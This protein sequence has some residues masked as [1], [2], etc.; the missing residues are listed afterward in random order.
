MHFYNLKELPDYLSDIND[1]TIYME[2]AIKKLQIT[3]D[4]RKELL[5]YVTGIRKGLSGADSIISIIAAI[6][7]T[8]V[9]Y[10][11]PLAALRAITAYQK[12]VPFSCEWYIYMAECDNKKLMNITDDDLRAI[13]HDV[14]SESF[15]RRKYCR[16]GISECLA[17]VDKNIKG[18][19]SVT[20]SYF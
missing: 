20:A 13:N 7:D 3:E 10:F 2:D 19:E 9:G 5:K 16:N 15:K 6:I 1:N 8:S 14:I 17:I 4:D 12:K 11:T 18:S